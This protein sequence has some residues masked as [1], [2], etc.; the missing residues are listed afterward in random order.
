[1]FIAFMINRSI[2]NPKWLQVAAK[3]HDNVNK[4]KGSSF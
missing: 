4:L 1:M 2:F 3:Y